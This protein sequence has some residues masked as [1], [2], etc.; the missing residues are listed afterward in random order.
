MIGLGGKLAVEAEQA[1]LVGGERLRVELV[2]GHVKL[3]K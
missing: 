1:L 2:N 3:D